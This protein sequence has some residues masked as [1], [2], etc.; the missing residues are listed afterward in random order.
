[1]KLQDIE[2]FVQVAKYGSYKDAA[3]QLFCST[4][5]LYQGIARLEK[6]LGKELFERNSNPLQTT[7]FG[8]WVL[9]R[10]AAPILDSCTGLANSADEYTK[11]ERKR[12]I[13]EI[14][15][16]SSV[17]HQVAMLATEK[18]RSM[19][20]DCRIELR[21]NSPRQ[22]IED[23]RE[24]RVDIGLT[25]ATPHSDGLQACLSIPIELAVYVSQ[26]HPLAQKKHVTSAEMA[27]QA[28]WFFNPMLY[29]RFALWTIAGLSQENAVISTPTNPLTV[30]QFRDGSLARIMPMFDSGL[31]PLTNVMNNSVKIT[32]DPPAYDKMCFWTQPDAPVDPVLRSF[33]EVFRDV[34][35]SETGEMA[36]IIV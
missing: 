25:W 16:E 10:Y 24:R 3:E 32:F 8:E 6:E 7:D 1:M 29:K 18:L 9:L 30:R 14:G 5:C 26:K 2:Y 33:L 19:Y 28:L 34:Y 27:D 13:I 31:G 11:R 20:P 36:T 35:L 22:I 4:Q 15:T 17:Y 12:L 23:I 21:I